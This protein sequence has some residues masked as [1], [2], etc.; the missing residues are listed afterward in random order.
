M[1]GAGGVMYR[2]DSLPVQAVKGW[3]PATALG[4]SIHAGKTDRLE[5]KLK[6]LVRQ[7]G[8]GQKSEGGYY[9]YHQSLARLAAEIQQIEGLEGLTLDSCGI[10]LAIYPA[11]GK[12]MFLLS[13]K[14]GLREYCLLFREGGIRRGGFIRH[15]LGLSMQKNRLTNPKLTACPDAIRRQHIS[16]EFERP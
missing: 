14:Q 2:Y 9:V 6:R 13:N 8:K 7:Y 16:C 1:A 5:R 10:R 11:H 4:K 15:K 3:S 12:M